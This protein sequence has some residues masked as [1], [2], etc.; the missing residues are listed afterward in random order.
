MHVLWQKEEELLQTMNRMNKMLSW[1]Y[2]EI[3]AIDKELESLSWS[4]TNLRAQKES[5][6]R[7]LQG[8]YEKQ[9]SLINRKAELLKQTPGVSVE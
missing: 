1:V 8:L 4:I 3:T 2:I 5:I 6:N 9:K 7:E